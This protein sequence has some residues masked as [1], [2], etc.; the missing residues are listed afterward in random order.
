MCVAPCVAQGKLEAALETTI[1]AAQAQGE[2]AEAAESELRTTSDALG[3]SRME[4]EYWHARQRRDDQQLHRKVSR[5]VRRLASF[6]KEEEGAPGA[7][8][9]KEASAR[10]GK[11]PPV[12]TGSEQK[13]HVQ[14]EGLRRG[15]QK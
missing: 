3:E 9:S 11:P 6:Y 2:R 12:K 8:L 4:L 10:G 14:A 15:S 1:K 5:G 7:A 13:R